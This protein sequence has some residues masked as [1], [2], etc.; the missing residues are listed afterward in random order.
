MKSQEWFKADKYKGKFKDKI[1]GDTSAKAIDRVRKTLRYY[2][3]R[4]GGNL[5]EIEEEFC[6]LYQAKNGVPIQYIC[7]SK[8]SDIIQTQEVNLTSEKMRLLLQAVE[9]L[10]IYR[11]IK[12]IRKE[13]YQ[14]E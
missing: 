2:C 6:I 9:D 3:F 4:Y 13:Q 12:A 5:I 10:E 11:Y 1:Q 8:Y 14:K 7:L